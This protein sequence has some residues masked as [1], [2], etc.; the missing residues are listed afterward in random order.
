M[1]VSGVREIYGSEE[2]YRLKIL[3]RIF[4]ERIFGL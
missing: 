1:E 3:N 4:Q 2:Q